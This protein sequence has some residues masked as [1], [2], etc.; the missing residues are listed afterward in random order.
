MS[1][2]RL[3]GKSFTLRVGGREVV[4]TVVKKLEL[5]D[6]RVRGVMNGEPHPTTIFKDMVKEQIE[7]CVREYEE[8][9]EIRRVILKKKRKQGKRGGK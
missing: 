5:G 7:V 2:S 4:F 9:K 3:I 1:R 6:F 8:P